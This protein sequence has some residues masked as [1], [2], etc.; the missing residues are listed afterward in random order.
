VIFKGL[1]FLRFFKNRQGVK[2]KTKKVDHRQSHSEKIYEEYSE[3][4]GCVFRCL[5]CTASCFIVVGIKPRCCQ[6]IGL[7]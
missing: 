1:R 2:C 3:N 4:V 5:Y 7:P 6:L